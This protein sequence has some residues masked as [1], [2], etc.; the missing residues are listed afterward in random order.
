MKKILFLGTMILLAS[1]TQVSSTSEE[2]SRS[3]SDK[4]AYSQDAR[5]DLC[6]ATITSTTYMGYGVVSITS[7]PCTE[8]VLAQVRQ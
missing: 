2:T 3:V 5:T 4:V 7:V 1:C 8:K 6:F